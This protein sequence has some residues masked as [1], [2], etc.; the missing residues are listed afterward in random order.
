MEVNYRNRIYGQSNYGISRTFKVLPDL[1]FIKF[2]DK[3]MNK[4]MHFFGM[5]GGVSILCGIGTICLAI[6]LRFALHISLIQTPLPTLSTLFVILGIQM[7]LIGVVSEMIMRV[8]YESQG[9]TP[10]II[11][12]MINF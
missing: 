5:F 12:D 4:P 3:Y 2:L 10:Y 1:L 11:K 7:L 8:Y 6:F 9:K